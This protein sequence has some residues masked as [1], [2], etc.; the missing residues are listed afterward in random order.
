MWVEPQSVLMFKPFG[1]LLITCVSA[2][3]ASNTFL[4]I[5]EALPFAQSK[6]TFMFLKER[7]AIEIR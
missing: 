5:A 6:A 1:S 7:V 2:P 4:A 3:R